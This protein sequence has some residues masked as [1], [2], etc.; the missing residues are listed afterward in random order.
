M[1][2]QCNVLEDW[3]LYGSFSSRFSFFCHFEHHMFLLKISS[4][5]VQLLILDLLQHATGVFLLKT[6]VYCHIFYII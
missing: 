1:K 6:T 5:T 2:R 3:P 4:F